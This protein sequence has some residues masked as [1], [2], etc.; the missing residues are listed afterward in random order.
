MTQRDHIGTDK[1]EIPNLC[2]RNKKTRLRKM[3]LSFKDF[4]GYSKCFL[5]YGSICRER[6]NSSDII[7][8]ISDDSSDVIHDIITVLI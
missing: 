4:Y 8:D 3:V 6:E 7:H 1:A 5:S 2:T